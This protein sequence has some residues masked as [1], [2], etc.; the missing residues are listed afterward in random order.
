MLA[1]QHVEE[2]CGFIPTPQHW[3]SVLKTNPDSW[4]LKVKK[5]TEIALELS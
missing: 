5:K 1:E 4:M 3:L 2:D